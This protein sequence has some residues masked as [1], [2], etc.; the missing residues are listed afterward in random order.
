[1]GS[2]DDHAQALLRLRQSHRP[3]VRAVC[4]H[5]AVGECVVSKRPSPENLRYPFGRAVPTNFRWKGTFTE[6]DEYWWQQY[7]EALQKYNEDRKGRQ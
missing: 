7:G 1:M 3:L 5:V 6:C 2:T 4:R